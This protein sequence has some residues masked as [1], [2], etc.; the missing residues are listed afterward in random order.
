MNRLRNLAAR[1]LPIWLAAV[2]CVGLVVFVTWG[3][4]R[5][6]ELA[7]RESKSNTANIARLV[8][9]FARQT[10]H[11]VEL[12]L[13]DVND[14]LA[15]RMPQYSAGAGGTS[16][17]LNARLPS[18]HLIRGLVLT[19]ENGQTLGT[20]LTASGVL[21]GGIGERDWF[22][23]QRSTPGMRMWIGNPEPDGNGQWIVPFTQ[24]VSRP[25]G[26]FAGVLVAIVSI[27]NFQSVLESVEFGA[28]SFVTLYLTDGTLLATAPVNDSL[29]S[30]N[31]RD[32]TLFQDHVARTPFDS[33]HEAATDATTERV[34][35]YRVMPDFPVLIAT[36]VSMHEV[37]AHW[38]QQFALRLGLVGV[39]S[40]ALLLVSGLLVRHYARLAEAERAL[41]RSA[42][43]TR[44]IL[45]HAA[46]GIVT[47]DASGRIESANLAAQAMFMRCEQTLKGLHIG[48]LV[49]GFEADQNNHGAYVH[50]EAGG[51]AALT[52]PPAPL[53]GAEEVIAPSG[54]RWDAQAHR[55]DG[56]WFP[57]EIIV[58]MAPL[59][60]AASNR[61]AVFRDLTEQREA[62]ARVAELAEER[63]RRSA[64][65][66]ANQAKSEFMSRVSHELRTPLN[67]VSGFAQILEEA[68]PIERDRVAEYAGHIRTA[69]RH[70]LLLVDDLLELNRINQGEVRLQAERVDLARLVGEARRLLDDQADSADIRLLVVVEE[71]GS[72]AWVDPGRLRQVLLNLGSNAIKYNRPGGWVEFRVEASRAG[73][74]RM[75][76]ADNGIGMTGEQ[77]TRL[78][79]PFDRLGLERSTIPGTGLGLSITRSL[80]MAMAAPLDIRSAPGQGTRVSFELSDA[81]IA[82]APMPGVPI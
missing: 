7:I 14:Q 81:N 34:Y 60:T 12:K 50:A 13:S 73:R 72:V 80:L 40:L 49:P 51:R 8:E 65:D 3:H 47:L 61:V 11:R 64:S 6:R 24:R 53:T 20:T 4:Y 17:W 66:L 56:S 25:D 77:L 15:T 43:Q 67:A 44:A 22:V 1:F 78:Y 35:S 62:A 63:M 76:I 69:G 48:D 19:D 28:S 23:R 29:R 38:R 45:N 18:D 52:K 46:D 57:I 68:Q 2:A 31:W 75:S 30:R 36:G 16:A 74:I 5:E 58:T 41:S 39:I 33:V 27:N 9:E 42:E 70:L 59:A 21:R 54:V 26:R 79:Q 37:L 71:P 82:A 55:S 10:F 32:S